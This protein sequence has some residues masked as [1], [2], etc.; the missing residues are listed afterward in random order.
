MAGSTSSDVAI[1]F[2]YAF[3]SSLLLLLLVRR[4]R[5]P[6]PRILG[7]FVAFIACCGL[8]TFT[9]PERIQEELPQLAPGAGE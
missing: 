6:F 8:I 2:A 3:V 5:I 1:F 4:Q 9:W 7:L